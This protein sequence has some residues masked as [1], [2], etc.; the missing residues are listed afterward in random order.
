VKHVCIGIT[1]PALENSAIFGTKTQKDTSYF[2]TMAK[3]Q[4]EINGKIQ[5]VKRVELFDLAKKGTIN[6]YTKVFYDGKE[7]QAY[8][9]RGLEFVN[10]EESIAMDV[11]NE[12]I[13]QKTIEVPLPEE[14]ESPFIK[15]EKECAPVRLEKKTNEIDKMFLT[16]SL[17]SLLP[18][19]G[20]YLLGCGIFKCAWIAYF[21]AVKLI[22]LIGGLSLVVAVFVGGAADL[23]FQNISAIE[24]AFLRITALC[25]FYLCNVFCLLF[26]IPFLCVLV[27]Y[28]VYH[29]TIKDLKKQYS[30]RFR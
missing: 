18:G 16:L 7:L 8:M 4:V 9:V 3:I 27:Y 28:A 2:I 12:S 5:D 30:K 29:E 24:S 10:Q 13:P 22:F 17:A 26:L 14:N 1:P 21:A 25:S 11:L 20:H 23:I 6:P 15:E 19:L